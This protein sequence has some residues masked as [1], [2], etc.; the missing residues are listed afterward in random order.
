MI[1]PGQESLFIA[2]VEDGVATGRDAWI[3]I[4]EG[5]LDARSWWASNGDTLYFLSWRD[6]FL[7]IWEQRL[8]RAT[9]T[10]LGMARSMQHFHGARRIR[11]PG[12][13]GYALTNKE[14]YFGLHE[15]AANIWMAVA[16][17]PIQ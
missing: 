16:Q 10:P 2:P 3:Q 1:G 13:F 6:G 14:L 7:C 11:Q 17:G 12:D 5:S 15:T 8:D 9:K 4:T